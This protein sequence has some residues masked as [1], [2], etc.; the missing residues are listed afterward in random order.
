MCGPPSKELRRLGER[1]GLPQ[2]LAHL[3][4]KHAGDHCQYVEELKHRAGWDVAY[5]IATSLDRYRSELL[6]QRPTPV[7]QSV[8]RVGRELGN[9]RKVEVSGTTKTALGR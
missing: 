7:L 6:D 9:D 8:A 5:R 2:G 1:H 4:A 3:S